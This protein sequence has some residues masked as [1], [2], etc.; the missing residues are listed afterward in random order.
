[1]RTPYT[2]TT[3]H[4][5]PGRDDE[6]VERWAEFAEWSAQQGLAADAVLLRDT[7][8]ENRYFSFGPWESVDA[9]RQWRT[10]EGFQERVA[11]L[12]EVIE[13]F[14]PHTLELVRESGRH[15]HRGP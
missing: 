15:R 14:E 4:V 13:G 8:R 5:K 3:W 1:M 6:F 12:S 10:L 9:I 7:E 11:R 2:S